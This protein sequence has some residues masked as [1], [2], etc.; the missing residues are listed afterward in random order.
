MGLALQSI[1]P[2]HS[3]K[4]KEA[5][6]YSGDSLVNFYSLQ[7]SRIFGSGRKLLVIFMLPMFAENRGCHL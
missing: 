5:G 2:R 6:L 3:A 1:R 7:C 4:Q